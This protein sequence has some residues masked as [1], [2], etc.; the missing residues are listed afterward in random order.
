MAARRAPRDDRFWLRPAGGAAGLTGRQAAERLKR[1]G[2]NLVGHSAHK[3]VVARILRRF[4][5]PLIAILLAAAA[6]SGLTGDMASFIIIAVIVVV[7]I[8]LDVLQEHRAERAFDALRRSI[9]LKASVRR[10]GAVREIPVERIA[11]APPC[12]WSTPDEG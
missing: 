3:R 2:P 11:V 9:I 7:S 1:D 8:G 5:E 6:V 12:W 10:D 4:A